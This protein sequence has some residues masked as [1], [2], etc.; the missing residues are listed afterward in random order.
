M[1]DRYAFLRTTELEGKIVALMADSEVL[2]DAGVNSLRQAFTA[3]AS[4]ISRAGVMIMTADQLKERLPELEKQP[5]MTKSIVAF[6][7]AIECI[8]IKVGLR[9]EQ[10]GPVPS[11]PTRKRAV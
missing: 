3:H 9:A 10:N 1:T 7:R 6:K 8:D 4:P 5:G 11:S 2:G